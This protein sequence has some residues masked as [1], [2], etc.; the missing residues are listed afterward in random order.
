LKVI[1]LAPPVLCFSLHVLKVI[2]L[3]PPVLRFLLHVDM[4]QHTVVNMTF[5]K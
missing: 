2:L 5:V 4:K 1:L 3:A